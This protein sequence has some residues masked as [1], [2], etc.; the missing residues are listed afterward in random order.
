M[1]VEC[2]H[3]ASGAFV[4]KARMRVRDASGRANVNGDSRVVGI[5]GCPL[6]GARSN[7]L[8]VVRHNTRLP[9]SSL[10]AGVEFLRVQHNISVK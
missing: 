9:A 3:P 2:W 4:E 1:K 10:S 6:L 5:L 8:A 7:T